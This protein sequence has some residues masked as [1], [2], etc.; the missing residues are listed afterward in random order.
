MSG[1]PSQ[2]TAETAASSSSPNILTLRVH[3]EKTKFTATFKT[4][5]TTGSTHKTKCSCSRIQQVWLGADS[6]DDASR[7]TVLLPDIPHKTTIM[8]FIFRSAANTQKAS[9]L[10]D[11]SQRPSTSASFR[12]RMHELMAALGAL[13]EGEHPSNKTKSRP[14]TGSVLRYFRTN[15]L[16]RN[17]V[18]EELRTKILTPLALSEVQGRGLGYIY[19]LRSQL[20]INTVSALKIGF[21]KY[22]PEHRAHEL[23]GCVVAPEVVAHTPL[24]PHAKRIESL[25]HI[26]LV[27]QRKVHA[28]GQCGQEHREW[29][30][31]SHAESREVVTRWSRWILRQPYLDGKLSEKW[32]TYLREQDFG[33]TKPEATMLDLWRDILHNFPHQDTD[34]TPEKQ[35][36]G[37]MNACYF[38]S[39]TQKVLGPLKGNFTSFH[40]SLRDGRS[41]EPLEIH[42]FMRAMG[43]FTSFESNARTKPGIKRRS[44]SESGSSAWPHNFEDWKREISEKLKA[45][46]NLKTGAISVSD[47]EQGVTESPLGDATLLPVVSLKALRQ[48]DA[49]VRGWIGYNPTHTGFQFLQEAYQRG[50]WVGNEPQFKLP[51]AF[52][53]AGTTT[54]SGE[55]V[56][57]MKDID[58]SNSIQPSSSR[59]QPKNSADAQV[60]TGEASER[61]SD[62]RV[63]FVRSE[64]ADRWEFSAEMNDEA[65]ELMKHPLGEALLKMEALRG[66]KNFGLDLTGGYELNALSSSSESSAD[67]MS[68]DEMSVDETSVYEM[69]INKP[70]HIRREVNTRVRGSTNKEPANISTSSLQ[71]GVHPQS[72]LAVSKA[73]A[74]LWLESI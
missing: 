17:A 38:D 29:F 69:S 47:P 14:A 36:A 22:H 70:E 40:D 15:N 44:Q 6:S 65:L 55:A 52:R 10:C 27:A 32:N 48:M 12:T 72:G 35:V 46:K 64:D 24:I 57:D 63:R 54:L 71:P 74:K 11:R 26:E 59:N 3:H 31:I 53:K 66:L 28:C 61:L 50:E 60:N 8:T 19:I 67:E 45:I 30:T 7:G 34:P 37:Y 39:L 58:L 56:V 18:S 2:P 43:N 5:F 49:P 1:K 42:D 13:C 68:A 73:K 25:I 21:T 41:G 51:K 9:D 23:A 33:S 16:D 20:C 62:R 4:R